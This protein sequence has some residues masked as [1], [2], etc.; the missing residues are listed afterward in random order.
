[1]KPAARLPFSASVRMR[2]RSDGTV[3]HDVRYRLD[4]A[5][6]STSFNTG[7]AAERWAN[8]V[9]HIGPHEALALLRIDS[10]AQD[11][12]AEYA[13]RY[14]AGK[15]GVEGRTIDKYRTYLRTSIGPALGALPIDAV[16][17][18]RI[19]A[20]I[21]Q[22]ADA[23]DAGK[24]IANRHGFLAG[25]FNH[26]VAA[27]VL[28]RSPCDGTRL[29]HTEREEMVFLSFAEFEVLYSYIPAHFQPFVATLALTG[30]RI[31]EATALRPGDFDLGARTVRVSRAWKRSNDKGHYLG[32]PK[33][34]M[35]RRT[36]SLNAGLVELLRPLVAARGELVFTNVGGGPIRQPT[37]YSNTWRPACR[38][39]N[40]LLPYVGRDG[41]GRAGIQDTEWR[42]AVPA[43]PGIAKWPR[44]HDLRHTHAS[45]LINDG[46]PLNVIQ[47]RLGHES[48][49]TTVDTYGHLAP[50]MMFSAPDALDGKLGITA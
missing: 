50:D 41:A 16:T 43:V 46:Q 22:Q 21:N 33:T 29:P 14:L 12:V 40:G 23:G 8:I 27:G 49:K 11:T 3:A 10:H 48:I 28:T 9:R 4:G 24:T 36:I 47:R 6:R 7:A 2:P 18:D 13:E 39:A 44:I 45:W 17:P 32:P 35:S 30:M 26:A 20:W 31:S 37:F 34:R 42:T 15:S 25:M 19:S 1:M 5:S 38:L